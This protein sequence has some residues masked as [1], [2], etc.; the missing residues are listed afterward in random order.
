ML[1]VFPTIFVA[2]TK[3]V[4]RHDFVAPL[5]RSCVFHGTLKQDFQNKNNH[6]K[7]KQLIYAKINEKRKIL[8]RCI[9]SNHSI[10]VS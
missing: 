1:V 2:D 4:S 9:K 6:K 8:L 10:T 3:V 5:I 7:T